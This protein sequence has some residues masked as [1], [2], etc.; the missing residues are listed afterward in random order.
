MVKWCAH[1]TSDI[2]GWLG[3][4]AHLWCLSH[5]REFRDSNRLGALQRTPIQGVSQNRLSLVQHPC[6]VG[7]G[8]SLDNKTARDYPVLS[9]NNFV[10]RLMRELPLRGF[11]LR[12]V[13]SND[14]TTNNVVLNPRIS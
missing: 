10:A 1:C 7:A 5:E 3:E 4:R 12:T 13:L 14:A 6:K 11:T 9:L 2:S 8:L